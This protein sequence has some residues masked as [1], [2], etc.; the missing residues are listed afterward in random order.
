MT[1]LVQVVE[2]IAGSPN[3]PAKVKGKTFLEYWRT[4]ME[5]D[6]YIRDVFEEIPEEEMQ[7][8]YGD[9]LMTGIEGE[10]GSQVTQGNG[11][12][13]SP[14]VENTEVSKNNQG[15]PKDL[16]APQEPLSKG[17]AEAADI[18]NRLE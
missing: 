12:P 18:L 14:Q 1:N 6:P 4:K 7:Q 13:P 3:I 15:I 5:K 10:Q 11:I 8:M 9:P 2:Q 16:E 17:Q